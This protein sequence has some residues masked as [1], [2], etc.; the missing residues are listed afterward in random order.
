MTFN[1]FAKAIIKAEG[2]SKKEPKFAAL[3]GLSEDAQRAAMEALNPYRVF[4]V[5]KYPK[6]K[7]YS[8]VDAD[9]SVF[10]KLLDN[11]HNRVLTGNAARD[12]VTE[13]L[14]LYT[15]ETAEILARILNKDL[16]CG[17]TSTTFNKL[18]PNLVPE[19]D[20]KLAVKIDSKYKWKFPC[21]GEYK[22]DGTRLISITENGNTSYFS[23][24]GKPSDFCN[25]LF[26]EELAD[27]ER[28]VGEPIVVDGEALARSFTET[29]NAKGSTNDEAKSFLRFYAFDYM[30]L[31]E[32]KQQQTNDIQ[33]V[34]SEKLANI[35]SV[36]QYQKIIKSKQRKLHNMEEAFEFY[37]EALN[38]KFEGLII[39]DLDSHYIWGR[40]KSWAKWKPVLDFDL[41]I[42]GV[43]EGR[44]GTKNVGKL[45]GFNLSGFDENKNKI[46]TNCGS[47]QIGVKDGP[48]DLYIQELAKL[49]GVDLATASIDSEGNP[50][51]MSNDEF[52]RTYVWE[53]Q[54]EFI[55]RTVQIEAQEMSL[56]EGQD[57]YSLRFPVLKMFRDDK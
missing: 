43:Y 36:R 25:G 16:K 33:E 35:I 38:D 41:Q 24:S 56:A 4:G 13:T 34:R 3:S 42:V 18:Y 8:Q 37:N 5:K 40:D 28:F 9:S 27:F 23:R 11:L 51:R 44:E 10:F 48:L 12:A 6:P 39:K 50:S 17:A 21:Q 31:R 20:V 45:G 32:W 47:L 55:G 29:L 54:D 46:E 49:I 53:H 7:S 1:L 2:E 22:M 14:S 57:V 52:F 15:E 26:D 30:T 19:F